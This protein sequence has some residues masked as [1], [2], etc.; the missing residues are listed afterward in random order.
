V[1]GLQPC[2]W[3]EHVPPRKWGMA[4]AGSS[5]QTFISIG[6]ESVGAFMG[7]DGNTVGAGVVRPGVVVVHGARFGVFQTSYCASI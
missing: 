6:L 7:V 5:S 4:R 2:S 3:W 1:R